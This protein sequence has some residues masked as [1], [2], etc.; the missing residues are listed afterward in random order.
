[1]KNRLRT[2]FNLEPDKDYKVVGEPMDVG[3]AQALAEQDRFQFQFWALSLLEAFPR[4]E[5]KKGPDGGIDGVLSFIDGQQRTQHKA[6]VQVK[7]GHVSA[8]LV[9]QL[10]GVVEREQ[11]SMGLFITLDPP[12]AVMQK[13]AVGAGYF[14]SALWQKDFPKIQI[15]TI[16]QLLS[17]QGFDLPPQLPSMY[18]P[19]QRVR[20]KQ[21]YQASLGESSPVS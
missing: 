5:G 4:E 1:M 10:K 2:A 9:V 11:A 15:R 20:R 19:A 8:P 21:G 3:S 12:T 17:G 18:Q 16:K 14:H 6:I 13:E 7:S